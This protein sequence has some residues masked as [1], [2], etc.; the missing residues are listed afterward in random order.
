MAPDPPGEDSGGGQKEQ[1]TNTNKTYQVYEYN[2]TD[3]SPF[4]VIVQLRDDDAGQLRINKLSLG[5][6]LSKS[7]EYKKNITNMRALGASFPEVLPDSQQDAKGR[8][9]TQEQL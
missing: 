1:N 7:D 4:R 9:A 5:K 8:T 6:V 3:T 2:Q